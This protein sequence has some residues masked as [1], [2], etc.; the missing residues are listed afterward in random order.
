MAAPGIANITVP[1]PRFTPAPDSRLAQLLAQRR[2]AQA[3]AAEAIARLR[4]I[5]AGIMGEAA[6]AYPGSPVV[7]IGGDACGPP[8]RMR[9]HDG[10]WYVPAQ[11][12]R[13]TYPEV[14]NGL[15]KQQKG[16]WQLHPL[17]GGEG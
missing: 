14:W 5:D 16:H 8:L 7:D 6:A 3:A 10:T 1:V 15:R 2:E 11:T 12:L 17:D 13:T 9:W 4:S